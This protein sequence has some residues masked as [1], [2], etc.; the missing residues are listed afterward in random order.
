VSPMK[1]TV[2]AFRCSL[3]ATLALC[4]FAPAG[5]AQT[6]AQT[7]APATPSKK[8]PP[9]TTT[10]TPPSAAAPSATPAKAAAS[11]STAPAGLVRKSA[12]YWSGYKSDII[13][14]VFDGGFGEDVDE[15]GQF[16]ILFTGYVEQ[17]SESCRA[18]VPSPFEKATITHT[19][20]GQPVSSREIDIDRRFWPKY[21]EFSQAGGLSAKSASDTIGCC[22][23]PCGTGSADSKAVALFQKG[24]SRS[25][26][27]TPFWNS[28]SAQLHFG[29]TTITK[30]AIILLIINNLDG[31][32]RG[33]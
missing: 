20:D 27:S 32:R 24:R 21:H 19:V 25:S 33:T 9:A 16:H 12:A 5:Q 3:A 4:L 7:S 1:V 18:Y 13:R 22:G 17:F 10:S 23:E 28:S 15:D 31:T 26:C 14:Q 8:R 6:A 11:P 2:I 29:H 30:K